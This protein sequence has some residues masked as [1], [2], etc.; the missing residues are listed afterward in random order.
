MLGCTVT[1][2]RLEGVADAT[3][4]DPAANRPEAFPSSGRE[5]HHL[6][7]LK[8]RVIAGACIDHDPGEQH[9]KRHPLER[10]RLPHHILS[11]Q[12]IA[13]SH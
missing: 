11:G 9:W 10:G 1:K 8:R 3:G 4:I 7:L 6:H 13:A 12:I 2:Y 5:P